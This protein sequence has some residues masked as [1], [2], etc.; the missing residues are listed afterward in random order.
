MVLRGVQ[1]PALNVDLFELYLSVS[2]SVLSIEVSFSFWSP[3]CAQCL[4]AGLHEF[5]WE[6]FPPE[7]T[8]SGSLKLEFFTL[9]CLFFCSQDPPDTL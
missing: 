6:S 3:L 8:P 5:L 7:V 2:D 1:P 4:F 9:I